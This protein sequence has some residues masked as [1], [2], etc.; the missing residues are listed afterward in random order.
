MVV[1]NS[2][3][4]ISFRPLISFN[5]SAVNIE[6]EHKATKTIV[7]GTNVIPSING[8]KVTLALPSLSTINAVSKQLDSLNIRVIQGGVLLFE[9]FVYWIT[10]S[11][12]EYRQWKGFV[13][14]DKNSKNWVTL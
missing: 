10:G 3:T 13:T 5:G 1:N 8:T 4:S 2:S 7:V 14:T 12:N 6:V 9:Y 11:V